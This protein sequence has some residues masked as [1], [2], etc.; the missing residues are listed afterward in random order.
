VVAAVGW[1]LWRGTG[2]LDVDGRDLYIKSG[3]RRSEAIGVWSPLDVSQH[4]SKMC[5]QTRI[6]LIHQRFLRSLPPTP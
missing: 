4:L 2:S 1:V 3:S 5:E 6:S